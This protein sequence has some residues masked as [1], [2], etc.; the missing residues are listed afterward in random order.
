MREDGPSKRVAFRW[1]MSLTHSMQRFK[2][3]D[4][5]GDHKVQEMGHYA[6]AF[7]PVAAWV[8]IPRGFKFRG[9]GRRLAA[10]KQPRGGL[11]LEPACPE[12]AGDTPWG[13][14]YKMMTSKPDERSWD[15][16]GCKST[17]ARNRTRRSPMLTHETSPVL[18]ASVMG[19]TI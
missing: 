6:A 9:A 18:G 1:D 14:A 17:S 4:H 13:L 12:M 5:Y 10:V 3:R 2:K 16:D 7:G 15:F 8:Q 11:V 19:M